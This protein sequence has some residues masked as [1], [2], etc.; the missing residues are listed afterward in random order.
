MLTNR[1][2]IFVKYLRTQHN[3][4]CGSAIFLTNLIP[5]YNNGN[6]YSNTQLKSLL[7]KKVEIIIGLNEQICIGSYLKLKR[8]CNKIT[9][10]TDMK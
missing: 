5:E 1:R 8:V 6:R 10:Y 9:L 3:I 7:C 2:N 4:F